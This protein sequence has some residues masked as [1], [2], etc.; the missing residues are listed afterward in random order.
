MPLTDSMVDK[1]A[2]KRVPH[3]IYDCFAE[4]LPAGISFRLHHVSTP[5]TYCP[6][7]F[8]PPP[9]KRQQRTYCETQFLALSIPRPGSSNGQEVL[10]FAIEIFIYTTRNLTTLFVSKADSTGYLSLLDTERGSRASPIR[11]ITSTFISWLVD[12]R[13]RPCIRLVVSLF[14]RAQNQYLFPGSVEHPGKHVLDDRQLVRW[15][16]KTLDPVLRKDKPQ[17]SDDTGSSAKA[18]VIVPGFDKH[19]TTGFFPPTWRSDPVDNRKWQYGHPLRD[20]APDAAAPPRCLVPHFPDDPKARFLDEL[21][22]EIPDASSSQTLSSP[23]K[24]G[25]GMWKSVKTLEQFWETM[26]FRQ[27]CSSGRLVGFIWIVFTPPAPSFDSQTDGLDSQTSLCSSN[28]G[29]IRP[30]PI[31]EVMSDRTNAAESPKKKDRN[32]RKKL[33]GPIFPRQPRIKSSSSTV[34]TSSLAERTSYWYWP[35]TGRGQ[36]VLDQNSYTRVHDLLLRLDFANAEAATS[37]TGKWIDEVIVIAGLSDGW[38]K[39]VTG[40]LESSNTAVAATSGGAMN[41]APANDLSGM[42]I[43][44]KRKPDSEPSGPAAGSGSDVPAINVLGVGGTNGVGE[45]TLRELFLRTKAPTVYIIGRNAQKGLALASELMDSNEGS[46][47]VFLKVDVCLIKNVDAVCQEIQRREKKINILLLTAGYM[48]LKNRTG[49]Y[50]FVS[51]CYTLFNHARSNFPLSLARTSTILTSTTETSEGIDHKMCVNY[52]ARMR[53]IMN[54]APQL[55]AASAQHELSRT[56]SVLAAGS[57]ADID[58]SDLSLTRGFTPHACLAHCVMMTDFMME[59]LAARHPG[60]SFSHSYPGTIK[61][62]IV[63]SLNGPARLGVKLL[64]S[65]LAPWILNV[66]ESGQ[67]HLFQL[68]S[69]MYPPRDGSGSGSGGLACPTGL[70]VVAGFDGRVGG[71]AYLLDWDGKPV[72]DAALL[73]KYR[74]L[75]AGPKI[76][77]HTVEVLRL[78]ASGKRLADGAADGDAGRAGGF[79]LVDVPTHA[80]PNLVNWRPG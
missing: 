51:H 57:E 71:G 50:L 44:K 23:S 75:D 11:A 27:E 46:R 52:Y 54:F 59:Q 56:I 35:E 34:S 76:W 36:V 15:W 53:F 45:S 28:L 48:T 26:A 6:P 9:G 49:R 31:S 68:T 4:V 10:V 47:A 39:T 3:S 72:G 67:R 55:T 12:H 14:A 1:D 66:R 65:V 21:D 58:L 24:K 30:P 41:G 74:A 60:T 17:E 25:R 37:S 20:I 7:L 42:I 73:A 62:G 70:D 61:S 80:P 64:Y 63:N 29:A 18:F 79:G 22:E 43:R 32:R 16:C 8:V 13:T 2:G 40:L 77:D 38:G 33:T 69:A 78:A 5:P 19:E